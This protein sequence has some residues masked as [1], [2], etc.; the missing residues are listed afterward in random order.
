MSAE[1]RAAILLVDDRPENL[2]AME[3]AL[4]PLGQRLVTAESGQEALKQLLA[5]DFA[6]VLMDVQMP[7]LDGY[8][9]AEYI[10]RLEKTKHIPLIFMTA[11]QEDVKHVFRGY[12]VGAVDYLFKPVEPAVLRSKV[13]V[14]MDL[15]EKTWALERANRLYEREHGIAETLQRSLLPQS[16]PEVPGVAVAARYVAA[17]GDVDVGGD[18]YDVVALE[19]GTVGLA[20]GDVV[21]KGVRAASVMGQVRIA[22]KAYAVEGHSPAGVVDRLNRLVDHLGL[23][24]MSTCVYLTFDPET[25]VVRFTCAG[26][27]PPLVVGPGGRTR[28][29]EGGRSLPLGVVPD[30]V[31]EEG[32]ARLERGE[33]L[34]LYTDGLVEERGV[35]LDQG[36]ARLREAT[37][38]PGTDLDGLCDRVLAAPVVSD[39]GDDVAILGL[40]HGRVRSDLLEL[41]SPSDPEA[42]WSLRGT[43]QRWLVATDASEDEVFEIIAA[44]GEACTNA[45]E[46]PQGDGL[47][48]ISLSA[49]VENGEITIVVRDFGQ[50]RP[51]RRD[52]RGR[53]MSL[54][55]ALMDD[56][57]VLPGDEGTEVRL[58]R[59]LNRNGRGLA[60]PSPRGGITASSGL[61]LTRS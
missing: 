47:E 8:E 40:Q 24:Q 15:H 14:F 60:I 44:F 1:R 20:L 36:L 34:L 11:L 51:P 50:W 4:E 54:M 17:S 42:L 2:T 7:G 26:H 57:Q 33:T 18:W 56:V 21:G 19:G 12:E 45:V 22:L 38:G 13:S 16:L 43:L 49:A 25:C 55:Q 9:T 30:A 5:D 10:K 23:G 6:M 52:D 48:E 46:H 27:P 61:R 3:A 58:R 31:Y 53:G 32:E 39:R 28:Y 41:R 29:L 35:S 37:G 59:R